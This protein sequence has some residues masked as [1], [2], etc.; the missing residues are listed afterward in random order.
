[1][2]TS[3]E[4]TNLKRGRDV[5]DVRATTI[6]A[7]PTMGSAEKM[8]HIVWDE[9]N[10]LFNEENKSAKMTIDEPDTPWASPPRELFEDPEDDDGEAGPEDE[11]RVRGGGADAHA[12]SESLRRAMEDEAGGGGDKE[13]EDTCHAGERVKTPSSHTT[14][15][16]SFPDVDAR[17][18][19]AMATPSA[20]A[21]RGGL[22]DYDKILR[23]RLFEAQRKSFQCS[24]SM[25]GVLGARQPDDDD[26]EEEEEGEKNGCAS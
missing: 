5:A 26:E 14:R 21:T 19:L 23:Q 7:P 15:K 24:R 22:D 3:A 25:K 13:A 4:T 10:L 17:A 20:G 2:I 12:V 18:S 6:A 16:I 1:M 9:P 8:K 11:T